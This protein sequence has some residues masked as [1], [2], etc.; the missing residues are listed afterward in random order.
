M[1]GRVY[2]NDALREPAPGVLVFPEA[3]GISE[4]TYRAARR[5]AELGYVAMACD[6]HG[7][8]FFRNSS[9]DEIAR[10]F[11]AILEYSANVRN[12]AHSAMQTLCSQPGVNGE[13]LAAIG[14]CFGGALSVELAFSGAPIAA[15]IAFHPGFHGITLADAANSRASLLLCIGSEDPYAP[16]EARAAFESALQD[17]GVRW[18][19]NLYGGVRHSFTNP[20]SGGPPESVAYDARADSDSW[21]AM[22]ELLDEAF[23]R[24]CGAA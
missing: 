6:L 21:R 10:R 23:A 24:D 17:T 16:P 1:H 18:Q 12:I 4:H 11:A 19:L 15:A 7:N 9:D 20:A 3:F 14:Y 5:V 2:R 13:K 8:A 22:T